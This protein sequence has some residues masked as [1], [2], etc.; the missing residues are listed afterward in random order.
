MDALI[1][2][3]STGG[4]HNAAGA[5]LKGELERRG[6]HVT[7][8]DP[9]ELVS[10]RLAVEIGSLYVKMVQH[11]PRLFGVVY[12][13]GSV[14]RKVPG[15]SPVYYANIAVA[16]KLREYLKEHPADVILMP[17]LYPAEIITY[18]KKCHEKLPICVFIATDYTCI[19]FTEETEC[20]YYVVP[21]P[22][23][24][25]E[26][27]KRG[28]PKEK[29]LPFGIPVS[30][31]FDEQIEKA[32]AKEILG[33]R[34]DTHYVLLTG[35]S[36]GAGNIEKTIQSLLAS[37]RKKKQN[38]HLIVI[39]GNNERLYRRLERNY[40]GQLTL[41]RKTKRMA[42]YMCACDI[43]ISK[44]G[45]LSSTEAAVV[46]IPYIHI[47]PIPG[48]ETKNMRYFSGNGMSVVVRHPK[49]SLTHAVNRLMQQDNAEQMKGKQK[50]IIPQDARSR[51]C[52]WIENAII[53]I[54]Q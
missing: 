9:Y 18:L 43:F 26:F 29:I 4:G 20:D 21:G 44:P 50:S 40:S 54:C 53:D 17:H 2:S 41:L 48:C 37:F 38:R 47:R 5:A 22:A 15:K 42:L 1:L 27:V 14:V 10:H 35:G 19:P 23:Q 49:L 25:R 34:E 6:H 36:I 32:K 16:K 3:C 51:I 11:S 24:V 8:M 30:G 39:C 52:D 7:M 12:S 33:L 46:Q 13:L 45:G 31:A 28:I